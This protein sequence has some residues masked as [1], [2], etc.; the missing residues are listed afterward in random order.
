VPLDGPQAQWPPPWQ[1]R[2][3]VPAP[4]MPPPR[5]AL[6]GLGLALLGLAALV[7][8]QVEIALYLVMAT[9]CLMAQAADTHPA[10]GRLYACLGWIPA[11]LGALLLGAIALLTAQGVT[12]AT[13]VPRLAVAGFATLG[14][15]A[16]LV[17]L[18]PGAADVWTRWLFRGD[19]PGHML[20]LSAT[21]VFATL[22]V[23]PS[24]WFVAQDFLADF[25][26]D[27]RKLVAP[28]SLAG[29]LVGYVV[30]AFAAVGFLARRGWRDSLA[31]LGLTRPRAVDGLVVLGSVVV[32]WSFNAGSE[33]LERTAL[34]GL[35]ARDNGFGEALAGVMGPAQIA[36]LG[37]SAGIGEEI[38]LRGALQPRLGIVL[39]SLLFASLHVQYSWFGMLSLLVFGIL[40][41]LIRQRSSTTVA[42]AVHALYDILAV[43]AARP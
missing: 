20:R 27:P 12:P 16:C 36:L 40:L 5:I 22:C 17:L 35:W 43:A 19:R 28:A 2:A 10:L 3:A 21:L 25:L 41:G 4:P 23:G 1:G 39:T 37:L 15:M 8:G 33:W 42:I 31:R 34:P 6:A 13:M 24:T 29:G 14:G 9:L 32:L 7:L 26:K 18:F 30:L 11:V 38:T